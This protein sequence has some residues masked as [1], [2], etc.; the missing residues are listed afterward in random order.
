MLAFIVSLVLVILASLLQ[1]TNFLLIGGIKSNLLVALFATL[2]H[3][4]KNWIRRAILVFSSAFI[5]KF[6]P[7][8]TWVDLIYVST[9]FFIFAL[10]DYLPWKRLV[11]SLA[12][13]I[14][15]T[16]I[17]SVSFF[18]LKAFTLETLMNV[19]LV[20]VFFVFLEIFY[21]GKKTAKKN[22]F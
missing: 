18:H 16:L 1:I 13:G 22:R 5:L 3:L 17:L 8:L 20:I 7:Y 2:A 11:N 4:D 12:A 9:A 6:T 10:V 15:G 14:T 19:I 21:E